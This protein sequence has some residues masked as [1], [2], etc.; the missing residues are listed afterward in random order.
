MSYA[1]CVLFVARSLAGQMPV[2][3][4]LRAIEV[5]SRDYNRGY[6][7][8]VELS[9]GFSEY[10][11]VDIGQGP[12]VDV[13]CD[14]EQVVERFGEVSFD[15]VIATELLEHVRDWRKVVT[16]LKNV[17]KPGGVIIITTRSRGYRYHAEPCDFWRYDT[18]DIAAIFGDCEVLALEEDT[19]EPGV[20]AKV[21][22]PE[23]FREK[24]LSDFSLFSIVTGKRTGDINAED[25]RRPG[26]IATVIGAKLRQLVGWLLS[27]AKK[28]FGQTARAQAR[29]LLN[30]LAL[31]SRRKPP[32]RIC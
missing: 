19:D 27:D 17:C 1:A 29:E 13:I 28:D 5:G 3:N 25:L 23:G 15:L 30:M 20:F 12:G 10:V 11:G 32:S 4:K 7:D 16:N 31:L 14:A 8:L 24:D 6:R 26:F 2:G 21:R 9:G 18:G 22:R